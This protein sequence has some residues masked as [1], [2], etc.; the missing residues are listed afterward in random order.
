L[1]RNPIDGQTIRVRFEKTSTGRALKKRAPD[2]QAFQARSP[3]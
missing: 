1:V 2:E 3:R